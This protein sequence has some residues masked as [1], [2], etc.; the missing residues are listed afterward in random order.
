M[1]IALEGIDGVGKST[2][3]ERLARRL[4]AAGHHVVQ[5]REPT[6]GRYGRAIRDAARAGE[7]MAPEV[8]LDHFVR[9]RMEHVREVIAP[10][11]AAGHV[12][13]TDRYTLSTVAYQGAR[14]LDPE[15]L[16]RQAESEFPVPDLALLLELDTDAALERIAARAGTAERAFERA[17][18]LEAVAAVFATLERPYLVRVDARG[19]EDEVAAALW[20]AARRALPALDLT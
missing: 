16:L 4:E 11:L 3:Q 6:E 15:R 9:D 18:V 19:D 2:Q 14:G 1:L 5:T 20:Q 10:G 17:S 7:R 12:V 13:V 8:E